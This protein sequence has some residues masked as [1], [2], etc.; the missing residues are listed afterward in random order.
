MGYIQPSRVSTI[1]A[2][3]DGDGDVDGILSRVKAGSGI[4][5]SL[6][7]GNILTISSTGTS[8][9]VYFTNG[10]PS[11]ASGA[12]GDLNID[13]TNGDV[14]RKDSGSWS[15]IEQIPSL[16]RTRMFTAMYDTSASG[17]NTGKFTVD[18]EYYFHANSFP[19]TSSAANVENYLNSLGYRTGSRLV[20]QQY[21]D[22]DNV[23]I[24]RATSDTIYTSGDAGFSGTAG[25]LNVGLDLVKESGT[26]LVNSTNYTIEVLPS[27]NIVNETD[28]SISID[29]ININSVTYSFTGDGN[30]ATNWVVASLDVTKYRSA[31]YQ[32][33]ITNTTDSQYHV[34]EVM[35][36]HNGTTPT[37]NE[38]GVVITDNS[39]GQF[40]TDISGGLARLKLT[41]VG[42]TDNYTL[43][44]SVQALG[45]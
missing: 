33:Q 9:E 34:S 12:D 7:A 10:V 14:Y 6:S 23:A 5:M 19:G 29:Q 24:Y 38:Y 26:T 28:G 17:F 30:S 4:S 20:F 42:D 1:N 35:I 11:D 31:K 16:K 27:L 21:D 2:D 45:V 39:L 43:K 41:S 3:T 32:I 37:I 8:D 13:Y 22:P 25:A 40:V 36:V 44:I 15:L 18:E